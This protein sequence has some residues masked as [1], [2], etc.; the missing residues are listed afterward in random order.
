[1]NTCNNCN[2]SFGFTDGI[3]AHDG[4]VVKHGEIT[5]AAICPE[6]VSGVKTC[7]LVLTRNEAG[8]LVYNQY[9][10]LEMEKKAFGKS[11]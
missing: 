8:R 1:M 4:V 3:P 7:K 9:S 2:G 6:C 5:V 11:A 10:A